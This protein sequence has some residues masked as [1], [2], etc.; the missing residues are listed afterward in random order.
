MNVVVKNMIPAA[1][2]AGCVFVAV[3][4]FASV[5]DAKTRSLIAR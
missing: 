2:R 3:L 1:S 5:A 4:S